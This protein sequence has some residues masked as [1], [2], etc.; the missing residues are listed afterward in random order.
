MELAKTRKAKGRGGG[1][2]CVSQEGK[3]EALKEAQHSLP[4][5]SS[6][7]FKAEKLFRMFKQEWY[8]LYISIYGI[9]I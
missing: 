2:C 4:H 7:F 8:H 3:V 1:E 6:T 9:V 5:A